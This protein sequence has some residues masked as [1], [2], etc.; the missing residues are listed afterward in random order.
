MSAA[1]TRRFATA[2]GTPR[3]ASPY[4]A[5]CRHPAPH[6]KTFARA[7]TFKIRAAPRKAPPKRFCAFALRSGKYIEAHT[8]QLQML[9]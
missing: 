9:T 2:A 5:R 7:A 1:H 6:G 4:A 8:L 3:H